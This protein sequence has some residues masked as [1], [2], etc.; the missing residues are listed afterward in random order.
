[1]IGRVTRTT[2]AT[3]SPLGE[4]RLDSTVSFVI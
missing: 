4:S 2:S 1:M 3:Y